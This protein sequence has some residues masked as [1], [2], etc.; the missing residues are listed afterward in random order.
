[1]TIVLDR[2][3]FYQPPQAYRLGK[4]SS[5]HKPKNFPSAHPMSFFLKILPVE[6]IISEDVEALYGATTTGA[7]TSILGAVKPQNVQE[8]Q[9]IVHLASE[10]NLTLYP[11]S[12]G[13]NW[14]YTD[15]SPI[16]D[17][18][19][20]VDLSLMNR[21]LDYNPDYGYVTL[22]PGVTQQQL[23]DFLRENGDIHMMSPTGS[24]PDASL[25]GNYLERGFGIAPP[26]DHSEAITSLKAVLAAT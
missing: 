10:N 2:N 25:I 20:I 8:I 16:T 3:S 22:E 19:V 23:A 1:M 15:S 17:G 26:I 6:R 13:K 7:K 24:S 12:T 21:I 5:F 14:G 4:P 18:N 9:Q 11:I